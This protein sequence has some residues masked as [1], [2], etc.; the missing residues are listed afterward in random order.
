MSLKKILE[1]IFIFIVVFTLIDVVISNTKL[2]IENE[3]CYFVEDNF[4]LLKENCK[5]KWKIKPE[6]SAVNIETN[7]I[8]VRINPEKKYLNTK[9]IFV[10]G[11]SMILAEHY[12]FKK[13]VIGILEEKIKSYDFYNFSGP[14]YG[15]TVHM[16]NLKKQLIENNKPS[17]V[18]IF[19]SM[20]DVLWEG[21][22]WTDGGNQ[23]SKPYIKQEHFFEETV[24]E[25][26]KNFTHKNFKLTRSL[27]YK[28]K[29]F[30][31]NYFKKK[32]NNSGL[33]VR[34]TI[35]AGYTYTPLKKLAPFYENDEFDLGKKKI[36][37]KINQISNLL[38]KENIE[39]YLVI[40]PF[41]D[42]LEYGQKEFNWENYA[43]EICLD[44]CNFVNTFE[45]FEEYIIL[46]KN[47]YE[48]LFIFNDEHY[49]ENGH[50]IFANSLL[51]KI[52]NQ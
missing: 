37:K 2:N 13:G 19:L 3:N 15:P 30:K 7:H 17:K 44:Y 23:N 48:D 24:T 29:K 25:D 1:N 36:K 5:G 34:T 35:Q 52:F 40:F 8:G 4:I 50:K 39:F 16:Y 21:A 11:S 31:T 22:L 28:F 33:K 42:T 10:F 32:N 41:A 47:W 38:K 14:Y 12:E 49:N 20:S 43:K 45:E 46:N 51:K 27:I 18:I 6:M 9:K 26:N